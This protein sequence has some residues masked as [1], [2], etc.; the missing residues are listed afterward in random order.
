MYGP[1]NEPESF[2]LRWHWKNSEWKL[3]ICFYYTYVNSWAGGALVTMVTGNLVISDT[4][5]S[6][7]L[8]EHSTMRGL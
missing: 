2:K 8:M 3:A 6:R 7:M 4:E 5:T 1:V